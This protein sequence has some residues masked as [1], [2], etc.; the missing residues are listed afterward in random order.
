[1]FF[2]ALKRSCD[3]RMLQRT[4]PGSLLVKIRKVLFHL[5]WQRSF[6]LGLG[7]GAPKSAHGTK[8]WPIPEF[9]KANKRG[10]QIAPMSGFKLSA[11]ETL[12]ARLP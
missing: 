6:A 7:C 2:L 11:N 1:M 10:E 8:P 5:P 4:N 12:A 3:Q 9:R